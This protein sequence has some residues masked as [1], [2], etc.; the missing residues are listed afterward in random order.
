MLKIYTWRKYLKKENRRYV[1]PLLLDLHYNQDQELLKLYKI[2]GEKE[3]ADILIIPLDVVYFLKT[4][5][6]SELQH[7][8]AEAEKAEKIVWTYSSGDMGKTLGGDI[9]N[10]RLGG[11]DSQMSDCNFI[12]PAL[13][14]DPYRALDED[15]VALAKGYQPKVGFV[16][17]ANSSYSKFIKEYIVY[18]HTSFKR[19]SKKEYDYQKFYP[20]GY[21]RSR[22]LK[23]IEHNNLIGDDFVY[24]KR[25]RAGLRNKGH[26]KKTNEEFL[27]NIKRNP[28]TLCIR[29]RGNFSIRLFEVLA[30]GRI[31][32]L[33]DTDCRLPLP[34]LNWK[35][36][37]I[38]TTKDTFENDLINFHNTISN[39]EFAEIQRRNRD[40]WMNFLSR[41][42]FFTEIYNHFTRKLK[43]EI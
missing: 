38:I 29:G 27:N 40:F 1:F 36:H 6:G 16:G 18:L 14:Q 41:K 33:I 11:F 9:Y 43:I 3:L 2:V 8:I 32:L 30:M 19:L 23:M 39:E 5:L 25:Y 34:W 17:H 35:E 20:S 10:F 31:P 24:R 13:I 28:Y 37:C 4:G 22:F 12:V 15:F 7:M 21:Y 42:G 26:R